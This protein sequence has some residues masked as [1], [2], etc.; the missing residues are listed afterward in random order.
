MNTRA[1]Q[2]RLVS[3]SKTICEVSNDFCSAIEGEET[4]DDRRAIDLRNGIYSILGLF[5]LFH[6]EQCL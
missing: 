2:L 1:N 4:N 5:T 6:L 3:A